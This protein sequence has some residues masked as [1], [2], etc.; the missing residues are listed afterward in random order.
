MSFDPTALK[1]INQF[2]SCDAVEGVDKGDDFDFGK[3]KPRE[4]GSFNETSKAAT[5]ATKKNPN[6][7]I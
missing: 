1:A 5:K 7:T 4:Y 6:L 2:C 3:D